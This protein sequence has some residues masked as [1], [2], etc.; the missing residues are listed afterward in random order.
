MHR[1]NVH[2]H[3]VRWGKYNKEVA[4]G[5]YV[6]YKIVELAADESVD[7][8]LKQ[9]DWTGSNCGNDITPEPTVALTWDL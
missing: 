9:G 2:I 1:G 4:W 3:D 5:D 6:P 7:R 8:L